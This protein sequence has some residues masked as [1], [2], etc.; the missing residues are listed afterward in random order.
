MELISKGD[1]RDQ[2]IPFRSKSVTND[3]YRM[4]PCRFGNIQTSKILHCNTPKSCMRKNLETASVRSFVV[5]EN[6]VFYT[7]HF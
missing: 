3:H 4:V 2:K 6:V 7:V 1:L 5:S